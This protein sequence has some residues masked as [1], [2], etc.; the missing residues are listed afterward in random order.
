MVKATEQEVGGVQRT[1]HGFLNNHKAKPH[2]QCITHNIGEGSMR[3]I[4]AVIRWLWRH[5]P[6]PVATMFF[7]PKRR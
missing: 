5:R 7:N 6:R 2:P 4:L 3:H 1:P